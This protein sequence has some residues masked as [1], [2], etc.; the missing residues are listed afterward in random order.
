MR[1]DKYAL[2]I[3]RSNYLVL[4]SFEIHQLLHGR[5]KV[6]SGQWMAT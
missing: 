3:K 4:A 1:G 6:F 2:K 5:T